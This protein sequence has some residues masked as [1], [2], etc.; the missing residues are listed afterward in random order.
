M[1]MVNRSERSARIRPEPSPST[2]PDWTNHSRRHRQSHRSCTYRSSHVH[3]PRQCDRHSVGWRSHHTDSRRDG[4]CRC[5][6]VRPARRSVHRADLRL[7]GQHKFRQFRRFTGL[8]FLALTVQ[9]VV[10]YRWRDRKCV[11]TGLERLLVDHDE[12]RHL[13]QRGQR[14]LRNQQR[15]CRL[16]GP[17]QYHRSGT[18]RL[19]VHRGPDL[20]GQSDCLRRCAERH[21]VRAAR[22]PGASERLLEFLA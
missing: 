4:L 16:P 2:F 13:D 10:R 6:A 3:R 7:C 22:T 15:H 18:N 8:Q 12:Q 21:S 14:D 9:S 5:R 1:R 20:H 17:T 11:G 19:A